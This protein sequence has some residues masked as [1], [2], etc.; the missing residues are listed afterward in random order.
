MIKSLIVRQF[1]SHKCSRLDFSRGVNVIIGPSRH[2]KTVLFRALR[3]I[4]ENRPSGDEFRSHWAGKEPTEAAIG[5][6]GNI[7]VT[8]VKSNS[9]NYYTLN[10]QQFKGFG[11]DVPLPISQAL[12]IGGLNTQFQFD[13]PF[14]LFDSPGHVARY[15][16]QVVHLD[17]IDTALANVNSMKRQ[18]DQDMRSEQLRLAELEAIEGM[19]P[20][21]EAA[22]EY[23]TELE[24]QKRNLDAKV[25]R[26][27]V[28]IS[29]QGRLREAELNLGRVRLPEGIDTRVAALTQ[30]N[31]HLTRLKYT[32]SSLVKIQGDLLAFRMRMVS[33]MRVIGRTDDIGV[34]ILKNSEYQRRKKGLSRLKRL[35]EQILATRQELAEKLATIRQDE[36]RLKKLMP[37][38]CPL[39][40]R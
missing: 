24:T 14:L 34:L 22:E 6:E 29:L 39:C 8:R 31:E 28:L 37:K 26:R 35:N 21:L 1:Q 18:N 19:F 16:N 30:A 33:L 20:D 36:K 25:A 23:I 12:N 3:W 40:G 27:N 10:D 32:K 9:D 2:G 11:Q 15:L 13:S 17:S 38:V 4:I 5:L 7:E